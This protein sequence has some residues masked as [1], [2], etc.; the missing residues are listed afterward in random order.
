[1]DGLNFTRHPEN[2]KTAPSWG[3]KVGRAIDVDV[4]PVGDEL[5]P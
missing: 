4:F 1:M 2:S 5:L 3:W